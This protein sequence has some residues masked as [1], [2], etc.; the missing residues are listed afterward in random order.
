V[1]DEQSEGRSVR[2]YLN[3]SHEGAAEVAR[4]V[5]GTFNARRVPF[6]FKC[7]SSPSDY[8]RHDSAVL[9]MGKR[10]AHIAVSL[11]GQMY[12]QL[13]PHLRERTPMLAKPLAPGLAL[14][15]DPDADDS[16]GTHRAR[17]IAEGLYAAFQHRQHTEAERLNAVSKAFEEHNISTEKP[18]LNAQPADPFGLDLLE[19]PL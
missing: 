17:A 18:Y 19:F 12:P 10:Y 14:A 3:A 16:F 15:E 1:A 4:L 8:A 5:C 6:Q 7:L 11:L 13:R 2:F 9:Y